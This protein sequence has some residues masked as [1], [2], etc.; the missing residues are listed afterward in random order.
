MVARGRRPRER[1]V[2]TM[3][4]GRVPQS[5]FEEPRIKFDTFLFQKSSK[6]V[7]G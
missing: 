4:P 7:S 2:R 5:S 1:D 6:F 3:H